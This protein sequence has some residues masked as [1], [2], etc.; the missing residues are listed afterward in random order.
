MIVRANERGHFIGWPP[1]IRLVCS[2]DD[3]LT[4]YFNCLISLQ[5]G[6]LLPG[7]QTEST[8]STDPTIIFNVWAE[9]FFES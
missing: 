5:P 3:V 7:D 9:C 6:L 2:F 1:S 8:E 4:D